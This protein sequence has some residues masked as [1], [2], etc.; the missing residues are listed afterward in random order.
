[1]GMGGV[2]IIIAQSLLPSQ[3]T[4]P[5]VSSEILWIQFK[6]CSGHQDHSIGLT[7][8]YVHH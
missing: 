2:M 8:H 4:I 7:Q 6:S 3:I 5:D 1:M